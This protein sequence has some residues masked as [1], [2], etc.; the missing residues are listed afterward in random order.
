[1]LKGK[2]KQKIKTDN[3][4]NYMQQNYPSKTEE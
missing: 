4:E 3:E 1:M 2:K